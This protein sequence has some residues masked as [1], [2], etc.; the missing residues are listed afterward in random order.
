M[1]TDNNRTETVIIGGGVAGITAALELL[2]RGRKVVLLDRD[3]K[4][5]FGGQ[6]ITAFGGITMVGTPIQKMMKVPDSPELAYQDWC[7]TAEF[8]PNDILPRQWAK[9]YCERSAKDI[10][11]WLR[12]K[13]VSFLPSVQWPERGYYRPGNSVPRYHLVWGTGQGLTQALIDRLLG[14]ENRDKLDLR[15][16]HRVQELISEGGRI[17]GCEGKTEDTGEDFSVRAENVVL[18]S[19]GIGGNLERVRKL[20]PPEMGKAPDDLLVGT[21][22]FCDGKGLDMAERAGANI[23]NLGYMWNY[24]E[25]VAH[26]DP[27]FNC[28]GLRVIG[29]R[30]ALWMDPSGSRTGPEPLTD[31]Y[32]TVF[33]VK[34]ICAQDKQYSWHVMNWKIAR[35]ELALSG[36]EHNRAIRDKSIPGLIK[37]VLFG[38]EGLVRQMVDECDDFV[39]AHSLPELVEKMNAITGTGDVKLEN[40]ERDIA[41][42][43]GQIERG[44]KFHNDDQLRRLAHSRRWQADKMRLCKFQKIL[45]PKAMPLIAV[46]YRIIVRKSLGGVQTDLESRVMDKSGERVPG[47][48]AAGEAAGFGGGGIN[49]KSSLEG[50]FLSSAVFT[51]RIAARSIA[52][53]PEP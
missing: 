51:G 4:E 15:F 53:E 6:A 41:K 7:D 33:C 47:L 43:D 24:P 14:H 13:G 19:G 8:G 2:D 49:G 3:K 23:T 52:G 18:A 9:M 30:S 36:S 44:E 21:H 42:Y 48:Y 40:M 5:N 27:R 11:G 45:D 28:Q 37:M 22:P 17:V 1:T 46:R 26:T 38:S 20:W 50:T 34:R 31:Y 10:Y 12:S 32:D 25:G 29:P 39:T 16:N 35:K